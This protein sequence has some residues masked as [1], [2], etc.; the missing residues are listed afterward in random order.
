MTKR[1]ITFSQFHQVAAVL[2]DD[3]KSAMY[4]FRLYMVH[5]ML[6]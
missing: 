6:H 5:T 4:S 1:F 3:L 2:H